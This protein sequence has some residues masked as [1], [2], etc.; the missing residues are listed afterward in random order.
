MRPIRI[1]HCPEMVA[2]HPQGLVRAERELGLASW[3]VGFERGHFGYQADE[4]ISVTRSNLLRR[5][6]QHW[7][8]LFR[9]LRDFDIVHFNF[10]QSIAPPRIFPNVED[11]GKYHPALRR[12]YHLYSRLLELA[13]L[14]LLKRAGKGIAVTYQGD[15]ARQGDFCSAH[16]EISP[17]GEVE[18]GYYSAESDAHKRWRIAKFAHYADRIYAFNPDLL[19]MLPPGAQFLPYPHIDPRDWQVSGKGD[20]HPAVPVILHAPSHRGVKGTRHVLEAISRLKGEG[21]A[22]EFLLVEGLPHSE[23]RSLYEKAD[24]LIDQ[25]LCGWYGGLAVEL[26]ALGKPVMCYLREEDLRFIPAQMR[27]DLPIIQVNPGTLYQVLR[28]WLSYRRQELVEVG[29][30]SRAYVEKWHDP[31]QIAARMKGEYEAIM[32]SK[33]RKEKS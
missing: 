12:G 27:Q 14:P 10:G 9:A 17:A 15:D 6:V 7:A 23:A 19:H 3:S 8:L 26:M 4:I 32:A 22:L 24:L 16:F 31:L 18:P 25:L 33:G 5:E 20:R 13:D 28:E 1:L 30:R 21:I 29:R 11:Q 2:G